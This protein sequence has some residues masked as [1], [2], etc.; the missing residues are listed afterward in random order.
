MYKTGSVTTSTV[1]SDVTAPSEC[2]VL[3]FLGSRSGWPRSH[4]NASESPFPLCLQ[5]CKR[6]ILLLSVLGTLSLDMV[7]FSAGYVGGL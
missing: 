5:N 3:L 4:V 7:T 2:V 1:K 6:D